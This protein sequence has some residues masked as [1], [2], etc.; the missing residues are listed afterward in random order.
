MRQVDRGSRTR[1]EDDASR[2]NTRGYREKL[3]MTRHHHYEKAAAGDISDAEDAVA[4][5]S[6]FAVD[7]TL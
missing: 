6:N 4:R 3:G 7:E 2:N 5:L 1:H